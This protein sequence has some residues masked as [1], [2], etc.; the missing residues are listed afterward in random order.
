[1]SKWCNSKAVLI[2]LLDMERNPPRVSTKKN[3]SNTVW[4]LEA[5][6]WRHKPQ[7]FAIQEL[8]PYYECGRGESST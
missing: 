7:V 8:D 1:M 5:W 4:L 3:K 6:L 2:E